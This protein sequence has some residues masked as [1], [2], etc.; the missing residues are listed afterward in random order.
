MTGLVTTTRRE[1]H[2]LREEGDLAT[3]RKRIREWVGELGFAVI[4]QTKLITA[5]SELARN[6]IE[7]GGGGETTM[8][9]IAQSGRKGL[10]LTFEDHG[11]GIADIEL[12][13]TNGYTTGGG[14]GLGLGGAR[15]LVPLF[16]IESKPG[17]G[18][19][20]TIMRWK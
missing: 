2:P 15:R 10:R 18:T 13:F 7:H 14:L 17:E 20:I 3:F 8:E 9:L 6:V 1:V 16:E 12:A 4:D 5:A 11:K 19:K